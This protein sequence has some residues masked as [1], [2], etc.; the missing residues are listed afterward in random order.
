MTTP[1]QEQT[2]AISIYCTCKQR[3]KVLKADQQNRTKPWMEKEEEIKN[4]LLQSLKDLDSTCVPL[5]NATDEKGKQLYL[6]KKM[7]SSNRAITNDRI[8]NG[9]E[10]VNLDPK[11]VVSPETLDKLSNEIY[12][13]VRSKCIVQKESICLTTTISAGEKRKR[14]KSFE[15]SQPEYA[16]S[17]Q[18][19]VAL[20][21]IYQ[22]ALRQERN[23]SSK[24]RKEVEQKKKNNEK[25]VIRFLQTQDQHKRKLRF[26]HDD[27]GPQNM[28]LQC[29]T[30]VTSSQ[31]KKMGLKDFKN[32]L[33]MALRDVTNRP[34]EWRELKPRLMK[35]LVEYIQ[36]FEHKNKKKE[37]KQKIY[38]C[39]A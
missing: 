25:E 39:T 36:H 19:N 20:M 38:M 17:I 33:L 22:D 7:V 29:R 14:M 21:K 26:T 35:R 1:T 31:T 12:N 15:N 16:A 13:S 10:I 23:E 6:R 28:T 24:L 34:M 2:K 5:E 11:Y 4:L 9:M 32:L 18:K 3:L 8:S 30:V 37:E 27:K